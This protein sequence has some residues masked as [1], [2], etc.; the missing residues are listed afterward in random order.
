MSGFWKTTV[1]TK[2][3]NSF[4]L[5]FFCIILIQL[6]TA[7]FLWLTDGSPLVVNVKGQILE[8]IHARK[9]H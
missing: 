2:P 4:F 8:S 6:V 7:A 3:F 1:T 9:G 5:S